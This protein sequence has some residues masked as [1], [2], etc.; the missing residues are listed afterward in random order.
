MGFF[1]GALKIG[2]AIMLSAVGLAILGGIASLTYD[3][4]QKSKAIPYEVVKQWSF[5]ATDPL[6]LKL[7]GKTKLVDGR[8]YVDLFFEGDPPFLKYPS[9]VLATNRRITIHFKDKDGFK[10]YEKAIGLHDFTNVR[11]KGARVGLAFEFNEF[12]DIDTYARLNHVYLTWHLDTT[13]PKPDVIPDLPGLDK[14]DHC[15]PN[16][17]KAERL[18]R[19]A[20]HGTVRETGLN[21]YSAGSRSVHFL[22]S[23]ELLGC[24]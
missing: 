3:N 17:S 23:S 11:D 6:G 8:I 16:L 20:R 10:V 12:M 7:T 18:K 19:L 14:P 5:D 24:K 2:V 9:N 15:A 21:E 13:E 22:N 4:Y 1:R